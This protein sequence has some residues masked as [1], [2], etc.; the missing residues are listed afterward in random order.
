MKK[1]FNILMLIP[2]TFFAASCLEVVEPDGYLTEQKKQELYNDNPANLLDA[3]LAGMYVNMQQAVETDLNHNYF[4]QKSFDY[5]TSLMGVDMVMT[6]AYAMSFYHYVLDYWQHNYAPTANRWAEYY[7]HIADANNILKLIPADSEKA[8][9]QYYRAVALSFRGYAY[10]QLTYLY[11]LSYYLGVEGTKWGKN[12]NAYDNSEKPCVPLLLEDTVGDQ[13]RSS[14]KRIHEQIKSDLTTA[15]ETFKAL[16][17]EKTSTPTDFDGTVVAMYLARQAMIL[18]NWEDAIKYA[19]VVIDNYN[20]LTTEDDLLQG[21]SNIN[22]VDIVFGCDITADN[23]TTYMSWFSQMDAYSE[24]YAA[25]GV[26]RVGFKPFVDRI[27]DD[28]IRLKWFCCQRSTPF[29]YNGKVY[30][31][32][33]DTDYE[34]SEEYQSVKFIGT[35]RPNILSG[36]FSGWELGDYIYLRS[37]EAYFIMAEAMAHNGDVADAKDLLVEFMQTRQ[38]SYSFSSSDYA[39]V[40]EEINF[41]KRVEFWGEGIEFLDNRRLNIPVDRSDATWGKENNNHYGYKVVWEQDEEVFVYQLPDK[42]MENNTALT[43]ADQN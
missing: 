36:S 7:N 9:D 6:N 30:T 20:I 26:T 21:F 34:A 17:M 33:R 43:P 11:Q 12:E 39:D 41:Q 42:E 3:A 24:G 8:V 40:V 23:S 18:N 35:G 22:L 5:L 14:V 27:A 29:E 16:N 31:M 32:L 1:I 28:D 25:I 37:E 38:P 15:Y 13:P 10:L 4:G 19:E 2:V